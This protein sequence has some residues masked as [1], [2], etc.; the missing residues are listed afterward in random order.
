[1]IG[2]IVGDIVGSMYEFNNIKTKNFPLFSGKNNHFTDDTVMTIAVFKALQSCHGNYENLEKQT[3]KHMKIYG[4]QYINAGFAPMFKNWLKSENPL[5]YNSWGNGSAMRVS[6]VAYFAKTVEEV[7]KLA[8]KVTTVTHNHPNGLEGA[9]A[10]AV[11]IFMALQGKH[12]NEIKKYIEENYYSLNFNIEELKKNYTF[13]VSCKNSVPQA[14]FC[15][16]ESDN[17]E[18]A[19]RTAVSIGGDSDTIGAITGSI[20]A[21]YYGIPKEIEQKAMEY[22]DETLKKDCQEFKNTFEKGNGRI[23]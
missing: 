12:K 1:M 16:L 9:E 11:A 6:T 4:N 21:A 14:I 7:K 23:L 2:A 22:L 10:T 8:H 3:V 19:I 18:D 13:D 5:P 15:F 17:F 20:A